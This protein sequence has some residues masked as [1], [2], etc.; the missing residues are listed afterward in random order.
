M[1]IHTQGRLSKFAGDAMLE[2]EICTCGV[3]FAVPEHMLD[4][5]RAD[6][7]TFYC[8]NGHPLHYGSENARLKRELEAARDRTA[9]ER[10]MRDQAEASLRAT[11]GV[12]TKQRKKLLRVA[13]G[14]CPC[15]NRTFK[16]LARHMAGQH[17][18]YTP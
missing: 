4:T 2:V 16:D 8:P 6:G 1:A 7:K 17:P 12:V 9:R 18:G 13:A 5:R 11:K 14:V 15:C 10:A 3:L